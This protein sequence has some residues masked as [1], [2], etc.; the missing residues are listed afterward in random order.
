MWDIAK[1]TPV[2]LKYVTTD[3][4][5][6]VLV[7]VGVSFLQVDSANI[8]MCK[9]PTYSAAEYYNGNAIQ[10]CDT[11]KT[12]DLINTYF[13]SYT[14]PVDSLDVPTVATSGS[15]TDP[16]VQYMGQLDTAAGDTGESS[17]GDTSTAQ[18]GE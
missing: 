1:L 12:L 17:T 16:N 3:M 18:S 13:L 11:E 8:M 7:S 14:T 15:S 4:P 5:G 2:A 6:D 10:V 9:V